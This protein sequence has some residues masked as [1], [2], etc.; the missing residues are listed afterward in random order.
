MNLAAALTTLA[1]TLPTHS[2]APRDSCGAEGWPL[3]ALG[4]ARLYREGASAPEQV[5]VAGLPGAPDSF[6]VAW[7]GLKRTY[8]VTVTNLSGAESCPSNPVTLNARTDV[9]TP[10]VDRVRFYDVTGRACRE[11]LAPGIYWRKQGREAR[12]VVVIR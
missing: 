5:H 2:A 8:Y 11:P 7:D 12:R 4:E 3:S 1:F 9:P 10:V 6:H